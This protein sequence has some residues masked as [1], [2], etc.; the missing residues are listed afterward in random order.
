MFKDVITAC[1]NSSRIAITG[2][3]MVAL[4][5]TLRTVPVNG[6][7][8]W[9]HMARVHLGATPPAES[10]AA[11]ADA[12]VKHYAAKWPA[13]VAEVVTHSYLVH[14]LTPTSSAP[15]FTAPRPALVAYLADL[16]GEADVGDVDGVVQ[17]AFSELADKMRQEAQV[18]SAVALAQLTQRQCTQIFFLASGSMRRA[19]L[20]A[21]TELAKERNFMGLVDTLCQPNTDGELRL[22]PPY[23]AL[24]GAI[25]DADG[26]ML[27]GWSGKEWVLHTQLRERLQF[28]WEHA[29]EVQQRAGAAISSAVLEELA[30]NGIGVPAEGAAHLF[31]APASLDELE[32][33]P[34]VKA[35]FDTL[36]TQEATAKQKDDAKSKSVKNFNRFK[37][38]LSKGS[39]RGVISSRART[40]RDC[41]GFQV[42]LWLRHIDAH[43]YIPKTALV[44]AGVTAALVDAVVRAAVRVW[45]DMGQPMTADGVLMLPL[46]GP[47]A[48]DRRV[49]AAAGFSASARNR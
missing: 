46:H 15:A 38:D 29:D 8:L 40:F 20:E 14:K 33:L 22:L 31:R 11:M 39:A 6:Y 30:G 44:D 47:L 10:A 32:R 9:A 49:Q 34:A 12:I 41:L 7:A 42:L 25:L 28:F 36:D 23:G 19:D 24:F 48:R 1:R 2:S 5:N 21:A 16:M 18:D 17:S 4:L 26:N 13:R 45:S 27:V 35:I 3:G 43:A 37:D